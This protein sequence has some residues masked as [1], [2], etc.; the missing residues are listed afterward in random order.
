MRKEGEYIYIR[1]ARMNSL[2]TENHEDRQG[3]TG[4]TIMGRRRRFRCVMRIRELHRCG[5]RMVGGVEQDEVSEEKRQEQVRKQKVERRARGKMMALISRMARRPWKD[6]KGNPVDKSKS[7]KEIAVM[8]RPKVRKLIQRIEGTLDPTNRSIAMRNLKRALRKRADVVFVNEKLNSGLLN[9]RT[10]KRE[11]VKML[12]KWCHEW[13]EKEHVL[14]VLRI[15]FGASATKSM[16]D[17]FNTTNAWSR[18]E[19]D[20]CKCTCDSEECNGMK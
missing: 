3:A 16:L 17:V 6:E 19:K 14:V 1:G 15:S 2:G 4:M 11:T 10:V 18:K 8:K 5:L 13:E 12:K 7:A 9:D 20:E